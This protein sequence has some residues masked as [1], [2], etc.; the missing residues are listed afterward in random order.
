MSGG[1]P[2]APGRALHPC[3]HLVA[4][5]TCTPSLLGVFWSKKNHRGSFIPFGLRLLFL[6]CETLKQ[7]KKQKL[8]LGS[9]LI[10]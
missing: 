2:Y 7:G 10:G 4:L 6:F 5:L 1:A 9:K 3:G 8:T